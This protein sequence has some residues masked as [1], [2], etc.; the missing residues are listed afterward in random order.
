MSMDKLM[1]KSD[2]SNQEKKWLT[3]VCSNKTCENSN[4]EK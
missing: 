1:R 3:K 4:Y 2:K